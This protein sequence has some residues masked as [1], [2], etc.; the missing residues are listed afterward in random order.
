MCSF[1][2]WIMS[3]CTNWTNL[4]VENFHSLHYSKKYSLHQ[5]FWIQESL[6]LSPFILELFWSRK[7]TEFCLRGGCARWEPPSLFGRRLLVLRRKSQTLEVLISVDCFSPLQVWDIPNL[8]FC[9]A[10]SIPAAGCR[11]WQLQPDFSTCWETT[12]SNLKIHLDPYFWWA[13]TNVNHFSEIAIRHYLR[14]SLL[15]SVIRKVHGPF[16]SWWT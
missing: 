16:I 11:F 13:Y 2:N 5:W 14:D 7:M 4:V 6:E 1:W 15:D 3:Y 9:A 8:A 10:N 12:A